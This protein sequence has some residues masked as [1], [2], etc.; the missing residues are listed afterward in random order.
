MNFG[1]SVVPTVWFRTCCILTT[2]EKNRFVP[3]PI[4]GLFAKAAQEDPKDAHE[5]R[6]GW[7]P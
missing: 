4:A 6:D 2:D 5:E 1:Q 3:S 7:I